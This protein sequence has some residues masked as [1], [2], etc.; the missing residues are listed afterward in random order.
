MAKNDVSNV[1]LLLE[2]RKFGNII[3]NEWE[4]SDGFFQNFMQTSLDIILANCR[5]KM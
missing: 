2:K 4:G 3:K 1:N 5:E